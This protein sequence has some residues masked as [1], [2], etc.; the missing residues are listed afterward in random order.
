MK[1]SRLSEVSVASSV[2]TTPTMTAG[3]VETTTSARRR[4]WKLAVRS[5]RMTPIAAPRPSR[6][7]A[8]DLCRSA[9]T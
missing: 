3:A 1:L 8:E 6:E 5:R 2:S 9:L 4:D 7:F